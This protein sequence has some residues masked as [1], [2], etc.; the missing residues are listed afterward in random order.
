MQHAGERGRL[1]DRELARVLAE[2]GA[3]RGFDTVGAVAE[4]DRVQILLEDLILAELLLELDRE[5]RL[6]DLLGDRSLREDVGLHAVGVGRVRAGV[7]V[8]HELFGDRRGSLYRAPLHHVG[9]GGTQDP[10]DVDAG[11]VVEAVVLGG[12]HGIDHVGRDLGQRHDRPIDRPVQC[13]EQMPVSVVEIRGLDRRQRLGQRDARVRDVEPDAR[14]RHQHE[15]RQQQQQPPSASQ[16]RLLRGWRR[17]A[18]GALRCRA[19]G[20]GG[21]PGSRGALRG[22]PGSVGLPIRIWGRTA[23]HGDSDAS[24]ALGAAEGLR[25]ATV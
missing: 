19:G 16:E 17:A 21:A 12:D 11:V 14:E 9:V 18:R 20:R 24:N 25:V 6:A 1:E 22:V 10:G 3:C 8:L 4:V 15:R 23:S 2:V 5:E 7:D 13:R